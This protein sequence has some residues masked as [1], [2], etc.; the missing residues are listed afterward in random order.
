MES[1][2]KEIEKIEKKDCEELLFWFC[3]WAESK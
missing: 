2:E 3:H 1:I